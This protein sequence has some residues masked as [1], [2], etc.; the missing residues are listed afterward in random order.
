MTAKVG[1]A[2]GLT[3]G[4]VAIGGLQSKTMKLNGA[5]IDVSNDDSD[6]LRELLIAGGE[7]VLDTKSIDLS[8]SGV[9]VDETLREDWMN[10]DTAKTL[11]VTFASGATLSGTFCMTDYSEKMAYKEAITVDVTFQSSGAWTY[12][13]AA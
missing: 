9:V 11:Q 6:G 10:G 8:L 7:A 3:W 1:R 4:G 2:V 12:T 5:P 13:P